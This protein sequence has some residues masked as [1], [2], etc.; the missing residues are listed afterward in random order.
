M[1]A[2]HLGVGGVLAGVPARLEHHLAA[3]LGG[4]LAPVDAHVADP[5]VDADA[6]LDLALDVG[7]QRAA[8]DRELHRDPHRPVVV[9]G[10]RGDHAE[11]HDVAAQLGVDHRFED[12]QHLVPAWARDR[13]VGRAAMGS[14]LPVPAV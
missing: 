8:T 14:I 11:R 1:V 10:D 4:H 2:G 9:D 13:P 5:G 7:A 6:G 12:G 3:L